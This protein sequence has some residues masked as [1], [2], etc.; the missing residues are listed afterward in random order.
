MTYIK[1]NPEKYGFYR[2][3]TILF[4]LYLYFITHISCAQIDNR[5]FEQRF[6]LDSNQKLSFRFACLG[7][8]KNNEFFGP[9]A[10]GYTLFGYQLNP[11]L[12]YQ[13]APHVVL[14]AGVYFKSDFGQERITQIAPTFTVKIRH[15]N[16][17]YLFGTL[18][19]SIHHRLVEPL[20]NFE[21]LLQQRIENGL[22]INH[23]TD[24]T[25]FDFWVSYPKNTLPGYTRQEQFWG[26]VSFEQRI[27]NRKTETGWHLSIPLQLTVFHAGGQ[28][29]VSPLPVRT[30]LNAAGSL[31]LT[32]QNP[33][34]SFFRSARLDTYVVG[35]S[36]N[37]QKKYTGGGF[38]PNLTL[39][40]RPVTVLVSYWNGNNYRAEYGGDLYQSY[41]RRFNSVYQEANRQLLILRFL[42]NIP[43][44]DGFSVT[45][46]FEPHYDM[47][48]GKFEHSE[49]VYINFRR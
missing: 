28:N 39:N 40:L 3:L 45:A 23:Q 7:F 32:W 6:R 17:N 33:A 2:N 49:G 42:K 10:D 34:N 20:Y 44:T 36:E 31:S 11:R 48:N 43:I 25:F 29:I 9:I 37:A 41:T 1:Q 38:Y 26:G 13:P 18:E 24:Q 15:K 12:A 46:R 30:A 22:Q 35:Y 47:N 19:G 8:A 4:I 21:R 14:E 27:G 16:W 5:N